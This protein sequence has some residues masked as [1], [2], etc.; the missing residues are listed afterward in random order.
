MQHRRS[1]I[2]VAGL[3]V[4]IAGPV[5]AEPDPSTPKGALRAFYEAMEAGDAAAVRACLYT[6]TDAERQ[7][8]DAYAAQLTGA[9]TLGDAAKAKFAAAGDALSK[10]L[11]VRDEIGRLES[12]EVKV[13]GPRATVRLP[14][15]PRPL[16]MVQ[17]E[18]RW[19]LALAAYAGATSPESLAGQTAVLNDMAGV[20]QSVAD[21][22]N[23]DKFAT[24]TDAQR[25]LQKKLQGVLF[26]ALQK[27]PPTTQPATATSATRPNLPP[28][29]N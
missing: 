21:E 17:S 15:Q 2:W 28:A 10:G 27:N 29:R 14:G 18:G 11:P 6:A 19:R 23:A 1:L 22:I 25:A 9:K 3:L 5:L 13:D 8:A 16:T 26:T 20:F 12:A 4:L 24:A 7:L